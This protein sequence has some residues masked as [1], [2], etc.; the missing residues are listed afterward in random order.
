MKK[1]YYIVLSFIFL[2]MLSGCGTNTPKAK[3]EEYL[4]RYTSLSDEVKVDIDTAV[5]SSGL[6]V[7]NQEQYKKVLERQYK[8]I[9]YEVKDESI[10]GDEAIVTVKLTVYDLYKSDKSSLEYLGTNPA[11]FYVDNVL[12]QDLYDEYRVK[13]MLS[14][15][16]TVDYEVNFYLTKKNGTWV[17]ENPDNTTLEKIHGLYNYE[18]Q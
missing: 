1:V 12:N 16:D 13:N 9:K 17:L 7:S 3:T 8:N 14:M 4:S 18:A 6:S 2:F 5:N 10:D 11:E 15:T